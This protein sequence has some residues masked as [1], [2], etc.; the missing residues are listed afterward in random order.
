[1]DCMQAHRG[2][3]TSGISREQYLEYKL[4]VATKDN[5]Q[6]TDAAVERD[7]VIA[8]LR[9]EL[10]NSK[11]QVAKLEQMLGVDTFLATR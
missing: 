1:M 3:A 11:N 4:N 5:Q 8:N 6:L 9:R 7:N 2:M 10:S